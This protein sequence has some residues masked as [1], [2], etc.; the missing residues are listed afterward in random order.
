MITL[1]AKITL[2]DGTEIPIN[3]K[4]ALSIDES[5]IDRGDIIL[6]SWGIISNGG[7]IRFNDYNGTIKSLA[8]NIKLTSKT[9]INVYLNDTLFKSTIQIGEFFSEKWNYD[10]N[11]SQVSVNITDGM[12]K[13]QDIAITPMK[14][15]LSSE[16]YSLSATVIYEILCEEAINNGFNILR[17]TDLG[18][19]SSTLEHLNKIVIP[20]PYIEASNLWR[21]LNDFAVAFQLHIYKNRKGVIVCV[22]NGGD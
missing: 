9:K 3:K 12:Q 13:M 7:S 1:T 6:P 11:N 19:D 8:Q 20:F 15:K 22:Y 21:A 14:Y 4:N 16:D 2:A 10:N 18:F 5:I 17:T